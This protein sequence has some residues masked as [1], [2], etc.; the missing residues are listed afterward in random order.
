MSGIYVELN[1]WIPTSPF[2]LSPY[3]TNPAVSSARLGLRLLFKISIS[4]L[5]SLVQHQANS[6]CVPIASGVY[7]A[8][9]LGL[10]GP[11]AMERTQGE[12][13]SRSKLRGARERI[14][15]SVGYVF[16]HFDGLALAPPALTTYHCFSV[17]TERQVPS[18]FTLTSWTMGAS[19]LCW[20]LFPRD[21]QGINWWFPGTCKGEASYNTWPFLCSF[22]LLITR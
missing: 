6:A 10:P 19:P 8:M 15:L 13:G 4:Y 5:L 11:H 18:C 1:P 21:L 14:P 16:P 12:Q 22:L 20:T 17:W 7:M 9:T 3:G 2:S